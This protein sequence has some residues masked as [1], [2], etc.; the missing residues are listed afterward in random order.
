MRE[1]I[2]NEA[3]VKSTFSSHAT[4]AAIGI[5]ATQV[6]LFAPIAERVVIAQKTVKYTPVEKLQDAYLNLLAGGQ[7]MVEINKRILTQ[8]LKQ[9]VTFLEI[10]PLRLE[11]ELRKVQR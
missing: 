6:G 5:K 10:I 4:L 7:G 9:P 8:N 3:G 11:D 1:S 2:G